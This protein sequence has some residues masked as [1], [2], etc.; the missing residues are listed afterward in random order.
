[1]KEKRKSKLSSFLKGVTFIF[2]VAI[3]AEAFVLFAAPVL[4]VDITETINYVSNQIN[5]ARGNFQTVNVFKGTTHTLEGG[6][7]MEGTGKPQ[8]SA[9]LSSPVNTG[10]EYSFD[11]TTY[12]YRALLSSAQQSVYNQ[13]YANALESYT[14]TFTLVTSLS[15]D[16]LSDTMNAV[17]ND[18]PELFWL[19]TSYKYGYNSSGNVVQVQ[20]S[21]GI[22]SSNL[23]AAKASF[24]AAAEAIITT[25]ESYDTDIEKELYVHDAICEMTGY[26]TNA[27]LNQSAYSAL[28]SGSTVC[29]GYARAFQYCCQQLGL[30]CYYVTG[31][32]SGGDHA[33]NIISISDNFYNVDLTWDDSISESYSSNVYTYFNLTDDE[34]STDHT[35]SALSAK[36]AACTATEMSYS[37]VY[38]STVTIDD[39]TNDSNSQITDGNF[40]I[41]PPDE[42]VVDWRNEPSHA[43][44]TQPVGQG[45]AGKEPMGN[46]MNGGLMQPGGMQAN[47]EG[48]MRK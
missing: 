32:A 15:E 35:R 30:T 20:L 42:P 14:S 46:N 31:T 6:G 16:D 18:H 41:A 39:I 10:S 11:E 40:T 38:G 3:L 7:P 44:N 17:F 28:V 34:I 45:N 37:S 26:D 27:S 36:L 43:D 21:Y 4:G 47:G 12:P 1:M 24:D 25:A 29:A 8:N 22:S 48:G 5:A 2:G 9:S 23:E 19:N 13:I 33:W